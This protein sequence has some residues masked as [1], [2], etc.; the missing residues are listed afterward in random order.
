MTKK[1][2]LTLCAA[3]LVAACAL[4]AYVHAQKK[5]DAPARP[6]DRHDAKTHAECPFMTDRQTPG[7]KSDAPAGGGHDAHHA[8]VNARGEAAMGF[9]Q[10]ETAHHFFLTRDGGVIQVEV[11]DAADA[12]NRERVRLH[13]AHVARMFAA[14][15]FD[16]P[17][18]VHARTVPG[19][20]AMSRL[21]A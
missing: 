11:K 5:A 20:P 4:T 15:D 2:S 7:G 8:A 13:L 10:T 17:M 14:G 9:S 19:A 3:A 6:P 12:A 21:K 1:I 16:T 18:L